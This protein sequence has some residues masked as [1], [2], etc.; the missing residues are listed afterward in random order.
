MLFVELLKIFK[1]KWTLLTKITILQ[2]HKFKKE[3]EWARFEYGIRRTF[4]DELETAVK[5]DEK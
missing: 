2:E 4:L 3:E 5:K 1:K